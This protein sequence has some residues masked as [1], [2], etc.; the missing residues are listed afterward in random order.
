M[1]DGKVKPGFKYVG[2]HMIFYIKMDG[3]FTRKYILV[4]SGHNTAPPSSITKSSV[5]TKE[6]VRLAFLISGMSDLDICACNIGNAYLNAPCWRE[7]MDRSRI[8]IWD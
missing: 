2:T 5:V 7:N 6:S 4:A 8:R 3:N 1:R